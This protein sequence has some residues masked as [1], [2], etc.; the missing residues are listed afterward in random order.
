MITFLSKL[1][2][3][4]LKED[5]SDQ[6]SYEQ[7]RSELSISLPNEYVSVLK[8]YSGSI[9]F[10]NGAAF[11]PKQ[12]TPVDSSNNFQSLEVLYGLSGDSNLIKINK[13]YKDQIPAGFITIGEAVGGNQ[14]CISINGGGI[15]F[16]FH[17]AKYS[18]ESLFLVSNSLDDFINSLM[19]DDPQLECTRDIDDS[20]SFLDF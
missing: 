11:K 5:F 6:C 17:E 4:T 10:D 16:W 3:R 18:D 19:V 12:K 20:E 8:F 1:G 7:I 2:T 14:I 13:M 9:V 15:Y